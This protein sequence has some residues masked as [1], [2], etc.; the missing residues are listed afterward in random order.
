MLI[1]NRGE[2][3]LRIARACKKLGLEYV[4]IASEADK[5][6]LFVRSAENVCIVGP[7]APQH[8]YLNAKRI[9]EAALEHGCDALHPGYG[10]LSENADFAA[11]VT[12]NGITFV[13]PSSESIRALGSKTEA[14]KLVSAF[15]VPFA[16]GAAGGLADADLIARAV[17]IGFP[18]I[19]KAVAGGGGRGMRVVNS[20]DE[21]K[22]ALPLARGEAK[23]NFANDDVYLEKY[24]LN[25]RHV[26]VQIF[27]DMHG[28]VIHLG[29]RDC[30]TQRR[31]QKLIEEAPA[32]GIPEKIRA[33]I[34][35][36]A[37]KAAKSA[38]YVNAGTVE[39]LFD[40]RGFYF[41]EMNTRIQV[42][43]PVTEQI[44]GI[45]LVELQ[46]KVAM[47][48]E[49]PAQNSIK[50][51]GHAIEFR[52]Y[53]EDALKNFAPATGTVTRLS[54]KLE[55]YFREELGVE[56]GD[57]I[58][59]HYDATISKVIVSAADRTQALEYS[60][61][62]LKNYIVQGLPTTVPFHRWILRH[63]SFKKGP[64]D[65]GFIEREFKPAEKLLK[66][67]AVSDLR[68]P[69]FKHGP[70]N[71]EVVEYLR[72]S[73]R[74]FQTEYTLEVLHRKDGVFVISPI[75]ADNRAA[76]KFCRASNGL[77]TALESIITQVL[78]KVPPADVLYG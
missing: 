58:T 51:S 31:H 21:M 25:P 45:D 75:Q 29:T 57:K 52:V 46:F 5:D 59:P 7:A 67:L 66:D 41:L 30:S 78:E 68:D 76:A 37:V 77:N 8:S 26:E 22:S 3:A 6:T 35:A 71:T 15:G 33:D 62:I 11:A 4:Q 10:F 53:A 38:N 32:P 44:T 64:V 18:V 73:A 36:A 50:F 13:G 16:P 72:Y 27:G 63:P 12:E 39:F 69:L 43:H 70:D 28:N 23:K 60:E 20:V 9:I 55:P 49:L 17:E 19:I 56:Q 40:G 61:E 24:I 65:I 47:G 1:A 2:I 34:H 42:E 14:R 48:E 74:N 54:R